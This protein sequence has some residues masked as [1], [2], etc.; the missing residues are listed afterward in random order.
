MTDVDV[1]MKVLSLVV[2]YFVHNNN[3][4]HL[5]HIIPNNVPYTSLLCALNSEMLIMLCIF[6]CVV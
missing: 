2:S 1:R 4:Q 5:S 6:S 3:C